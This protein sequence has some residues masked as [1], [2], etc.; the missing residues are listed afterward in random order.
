MQSLASA[1]AMTAAG[2]VGVR[3]GGVLGFLAFLVLLLLLCV[4]GEIPGQG[5]I[6]RVVDTYSTLLGTFVL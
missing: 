6:R 1:A 4:I 5:V 3:I 2:L